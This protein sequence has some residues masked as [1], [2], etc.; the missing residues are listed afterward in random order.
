MNIE[1]FLYEITLPQLE[2]KSKG[3]NC[4][5]IVCGDSKKQTKKKRFWII[6]NKFNNY[7]CH[8]F[9]CGYH[10]SFRNFLKEHFPDVYKRYVKVSIKNNRNKTLPTVEEVIEEALEVKLD[11]QKVCNLP[12]D[13]I[14]HKFFEE[15]KIPIVWKKYL[16]YTD[17]FKKWINTKVK[18]FEYEGGSDRRIVLPFYSRDK[19]LI[20]AAGRSLEIDPK[21]RYITIKFDPNHPKIF[22]LERVKFEKPVYVFEGQID[23]LFI[24][25]SLGMA[26]AIS[27]LT[28]LI[29]YA[30]KETFI[31]V[32]DIEPRNKEIVKFIEQSLK[33]GFK[34]SLM[35]KQLKVYGKDIND[36]IKK[37]NMKSREIYDIINANIVSGKMGL[38]KFNIWKG[39]KN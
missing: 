31:L 7:Y 3:F 14:A 16:L 5:C 12:D 24:P 38:I 10:D 22:G 37:G 28:K 8:C 4:K 23:S 35:P 17:N 33:M 30:P 19:R 15:R 21:M 29:E 13:H 32:P 27:G 2:M 39:I 25:N 26:G 1:N 11:I 34:V 9:N 20:G 6:K 18:T 36:L